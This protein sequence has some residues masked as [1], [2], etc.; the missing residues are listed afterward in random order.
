[1]AG[2]PVSTVTTPRR[3]ARFS[4]TGAV[5]SSSGSST[6]LVIGVAAA[7][8]LMSQSIKE[9]ESMELLVALTVWTWFL[10]GMGIYTALPK[11]ETA[12]LNVLA[13]FL[14]VV[15]WPFMLAGLLSKY[16]MI[17]VAPNLSSN[18]VSDGKG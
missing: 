16:L 15:A 2:V 13:A 4:G 11:E 9:S 17:Q 10:C 3:T 14:C 7:G 8:K 6:A 12:I 18:H 5:K 1:M